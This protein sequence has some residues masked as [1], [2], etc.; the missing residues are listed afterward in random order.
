MSAQYWL[1][2]YVEDPFRN[3][4]KNIGVIVHSGE[5]VAARFVGEGDDNKLDGR[6][7]KKFA[8]PNVYTQWH[9]YWRSK[10]TPSELPEIVASATTNFF[11]FHSGWRRGV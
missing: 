3:E 2:R 9:D 8:Y 10:L 4:P 5:V 6:S 11:F 7:I 1:A